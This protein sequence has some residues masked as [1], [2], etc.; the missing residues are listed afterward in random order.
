MKWEGKDF[1][2]HGLF[3]DD[4]QHTSTGTSQAFMDE[5]MHAYSRD[6]E[7][8][9][10]EIMTTFLGLQ[11]DHVN[12]EIQMHMDH[13]VETVLNEYKTFVMNK[14]LRHKML[15]VEPN[16]QLPKGEPEMEGKGEDPRKTFYR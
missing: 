11:V 1:I 4:M 2:I 12:S 7:I 10:G 13:Y 3:V 8:T 14:K 16:Y 5:F 6:F 15:P 9:G